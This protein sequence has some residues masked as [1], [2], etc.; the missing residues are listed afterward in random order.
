MG[1][2]D[3]AARTFILWYE[4]MFA[5]PRKAAEL[6]KLELNK[7][8]PRLDPGKVWIGEQPMCKKGAQGRFPL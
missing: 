8:Y 4:G 2:G 6:I 3:G 1:N 5:R 7:C